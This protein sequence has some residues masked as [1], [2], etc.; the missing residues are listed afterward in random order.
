MLPVTVSATN[1][2][3]GARTPTANISCDISDE[4]RNTI[5]V[6]TSYDAYGRLAT[7]T[8]TGTP[9]FA[10]LYSGTDERVQVSVDGT[11]RRF[12][13]DESGRVIGEYGATGTVY[14]EHVWLMPDTEEGGWE[15]LALL[16]ASTLSYVHGDHLGVP[17]QITDASGATVNA[18]Q[19]DPFGQRFYT[20][21]TSAPRTSLAFPGQIIDIAERHYN[22][23]R[24][25]DPTLGRYLQADPIGLDGG[26]NVYGYVGGNPINR[27]DPTGEI[28]FI[29]ALVGFGIGAGIEYLT[30]E[31]A[32]AGDIL[33]A[34]G[35]GAVGGGLSKL[36][37]LR[38]GPRALARE[39]GLEWSHSISRK[40]VEKYFPQWSHKVLNKR[41][42]L[43]GS[44]ASPKRH[45]RHDA[46]RY[47][48][49]YDQMGDRLIA[50]LRALDRIPDW[51]KATGGSGAA[52]SAISG[53]Q[54]GCR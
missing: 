2:G 38:Y 13:H 1:F 47:P 18:M 46:D 40:V 5:S 9:S 42:G 7:Y 53:G 51:L 30:N 35:L 12:V 4:L 20:A 50:P 34:G 26:D 49:G 36:V 44:W 23:Y 37:F 14:A 45:F 39:T 52:G 16:G 8:R 33:L 15:P 28:A 31:C 27:V 24:D 10:M 6:T 11:P 29:P 32:T 54:C 43:N 25:Y 19:A 17:V 3:A 22:L 41:G 21:S 48:T